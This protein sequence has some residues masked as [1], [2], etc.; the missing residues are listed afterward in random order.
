M[1]EQQDAVAY[2]P[3]TPDRHAPERR[4]PER[5]QKR[6]GKDDAPVREVLL[7]AAKNLLQREGYAALSARR[8]AEEAG[9]TKQ[10]LYYY[11]ESLDALVFEMFNRMVQVFADSLPATFAEPDPLHALWKLHSDTNSRLFTEYMAMANR[12]AALREQIA[13]A[14]EQNTAIQIEALDALLRH[15]GVGREIITAETLYFL[16]VSAARNFI[17]EKELGLLNGPEASGVDRLE[18]ALEQHFRR[19]SLPQTLLQGG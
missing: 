12:S 8:V 18:Q 16:L 1:S 5:K 2:A 10:L 14:Y 19:L 15:R 7:E 17:L 6:M 3:Q 13:K 9:L 4:A 11:F